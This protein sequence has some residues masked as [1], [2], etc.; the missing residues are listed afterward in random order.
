M[1]PDYPFSRNSIRDYLDIG[2]ADGSITVAIGQSLHLSSHH[3]FGCDVRDLP[4]EDEMMTQFQFKHYDGTTLPYCDNC[5]D[6]ITIFMVLHHIP[7]ISQFLKEI[8]RVLRN[9]GVLIIR[10]HDCNPETMRVFLDV[11]HGMYALALQPVIE[12]PDFCTTFQTY[13]RSRDEWNSLLQEAGL[14]VV[15]EE[16]YRQERRRDF[17][18]LSGGAM[19]RVRP[20]GTIRNLLNSY[21]CVY[22]KTTRIEGSKWRHDRYESIRERDRDRD[23]SRSRRNRY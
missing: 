7:E 22:R 15:T 20:D 8:C 11:Q 6:V 17:F 4:P 3:I 23:R 18:F 13:F 9:D 21:Y 19:N 2:C 10:E 5:F 1:L 12:T 16:S 14:N